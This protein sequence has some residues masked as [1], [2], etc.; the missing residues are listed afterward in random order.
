[1]PSLASD[2]LTLVGSG[3]ANSS[4]LYF[5]GTT[6]ANG[7]L[8]TTFGD[9]L[10]C[11][12]GSVVRLGTRT[13]SVGG[14]SFPSIFDLPLGFV[15]GTPGTRTYQVW[16]RNAAAFCNAETFNLTNGVEVVWVP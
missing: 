9:G 15:V 13:N 1:M 14:S 3:M 12:A 5:Q 2:T 6:R 10:R 11:A 16:Y 7:G 8:G 4:A